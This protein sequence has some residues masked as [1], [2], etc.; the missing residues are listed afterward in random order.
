MP[1]LPPE[2]LSYTNAPEILAITG[3]FF[4]A[5]VVA[6]LLRCYVRLSMLRVFGIDDYVMTFATF[7]A[8]ATF[9]CFK[10]E[11]D[12]G[13]GKHFMALLADP[14]QYTQFSKIVYVHSILV[15]VGISSVKISIAFS[16][17]RLSTRR[18]YSCALSLIFQ[19]LP[20]DAIWDLSLR[21]PPFG[22]GTA[23]CYS[24]TT[25]RNLGLM[26]SSF[27]VVTDV[28]FAT[29]PI[30]LIWKLQLNTRTKLSLIV[31]LSLGWFACA[32][33]IVKAIQ[34]WYVLQEPDW[35]VHDS[36]NVWNYI[37]FTIGILAASLPPL[38]PLVNR[39]LETARAITS[40]ICMG[41]RTIS[42]YSYLCSMI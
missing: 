37:E 27:N 31:V 8:A 10:I 20:V 6:V 15:M 5:A 42:Q 7:C 4:T 40:G 32:A 14:L 30:P 26:N 22:T 24:M 33:A 13:L 9:A 28:L 41:V 18:S 21:P 1:P 35:T 25:F 23:K 36:F 16:L 17:L 38:K 39:F 3:S 12:Y 34:Q 19:C 29:L 2:Y 11:T